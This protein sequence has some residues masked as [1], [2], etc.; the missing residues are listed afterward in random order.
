VSKEV[1]ILVDQN[2]NCGPQLWQIQQLIC[3]PSFKTPVLVRRLS[4]ERY[5]PYLPLSTIPMHLTSQSSN[6]MGNWNKTLF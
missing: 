4:S 1:A 2:S 6:A 5:G 3:L